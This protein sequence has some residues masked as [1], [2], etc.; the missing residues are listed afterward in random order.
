[1]CVFLFIALSLK[2]PLKGLTTLLDALGCKMIIRRK[3]TV[4]QNETACEKR[5]LVLH[6][7]EDDDPAMREAPPA[8]G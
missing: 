4:T 5:F 7:V 8:T 3:K 1:M 2:S 6:C